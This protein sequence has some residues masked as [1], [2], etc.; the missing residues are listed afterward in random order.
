MAI[1]LRCLIHYKIEKVMQII[2]FYKIKYN[3]KKEKINQKYKIS[4]LFFNSK[5]KINNNNPVNI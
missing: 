2:I 3:N 4:K 5:M 1:I